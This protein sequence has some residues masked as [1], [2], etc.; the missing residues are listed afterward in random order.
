[1]QAPFKVVIH[2]TATYF[3]YVYSDGWSKVLVEIVVVFLVAG[4][5][6]VPVALQAL[7]VTGPFQTVIC[8]LCFLLAFGGVA[9]V[10]F[11]E[12]AFVLMASIAF[13]SVFASLIGK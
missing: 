5:F 13:A 10:L 7:K 8:Y 2:E 9:R 4:F 12:L 3:A 11:D 6:G 1:M